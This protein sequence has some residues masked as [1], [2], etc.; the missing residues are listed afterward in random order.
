MSREQ[1]PEADF[2]RLWQRLQ[3]LGMN[4]YEARSYLVLLG[5]PRFKAL[6]LA[7]RAH[8]PRQKIYE[9]LDSL[10]TKGFASVIQDRTKMF[11]AVAPDQALHAYLARRTRELEQ[12]TAERSKAASEMVTDLMT[13][14]KEGHGEGGLE[15]VQLIQDPAQTSARLQKILR[16]AVSSCVAMLWT[17][18][19]AEPVIEA[20]ARGVP[21]RAIASDAAIVARLR[22][23]GVEARQAVRLPV[24]IV[25]ADGRGLLAM[26]GAVTTQPQWTAIFFEHHGMAEAMTASFDTTWR[27]L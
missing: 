10:V 2:R 22:E 4:A 23:A 15:V 19:A 17:P 16:E 12:Q 18:Q 25:V 6:E 3:L 9:V 8:V 11:S 1:L 5:H 26:A 24:H 7:A 13:V 20:H 14:H 21:C 27:A